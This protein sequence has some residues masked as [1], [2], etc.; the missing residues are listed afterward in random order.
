M[1]SGTDSVDD[2]ERILREA[3]VSTD[4][5]SLL[6]FLRGRSAT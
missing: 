2:D 6:A 4:G 5:A 3:H 1:V